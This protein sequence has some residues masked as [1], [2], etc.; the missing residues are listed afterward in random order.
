MV[1]TTGIKEPY[2]LFFWNCGALHR[3]LTTSPVLH[4][5]QYYLH[6]F[7]TRT[8][9]LEVSKLNIIYTFSQLGHSYWKCPSL[10]H[11]CHSTVAL[12]N[13]CLPLPLPRSLLF[14]QISLYEKSSKPAHLLHHDCS[15][16]AH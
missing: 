12:W 2:F 7:L 1:A 16:F 15:I 4:Q 3:P 8:L 14:L 9:I 13:G 10:W 5:A 11:L 6:L